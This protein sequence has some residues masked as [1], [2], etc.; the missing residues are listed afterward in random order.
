MND[1]KCWPVGFCAE[2]VGGEKP[3][4]KEGVEK[5]NFSVKTT[6][7]REGTYL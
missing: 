4:D 7:E 2:R 6:L 3:K 1:C 5:Q